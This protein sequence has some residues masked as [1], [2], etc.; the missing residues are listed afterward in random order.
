[1]L[2]TMNW[3]KEIIDAFFPEQCLACGRKG[4]ALCAFCERTIV[5]RPTLH[6]DWITTLFNYHQPIVKKAVQDLKFNNRKSVAIYFGNALYREFFAELARKPKDAENIVLVPIPGGAEGQ[7]RRGYN[8]AGEIALVIC[9][10]A[11]RADLPLAC[12]TDV[13]YKAIESAH[14]SRTN[15]RGARE[16]NVEG[17]FAVKNISKIKG[18]TIVLV[19]DVMTTGETMNAARKVLQKAGV[20]KV[21]GIAVA[22]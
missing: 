16:K 11:K 18:K 1:M 19:D 14:Q 22:H 4:S 3:L 20:K 21:I 8:H 7:A 2:I 9:Q 5:S 10:S 17:V 12:E 13:L 15:N 6:E